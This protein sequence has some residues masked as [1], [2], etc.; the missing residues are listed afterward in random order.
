MARTARL[1]FPAL[2]WSER[3]GFDHEA[4]R[5]DEALRMGVGGFI[6]FGGDAGAVRE[7]TASLRQRS[8]EPLLI[9]ADLERGAGQQFRGATPLPPAAAL[10]EL[11]DLEVT[12]RAGELTAQEARALGVNWVYAPVADLD[13]EPRNPI[14]GTRSFGS[15]PARAAAHVTAWI[16]GCRAGGA[17]SCA[18]HFPG[19]GRTIAD[20]HAQLPVVMTSRQGLEK[21]LA[22]FRAAIRAGVDSVMTAHVAFPALDASGAPATLSEPIVQELLRGELGFDGAVVTDAL[23]MAGVLEG[24]GGAENAAVRAVAAGCDALLYPED[25]AA[26]ASALDA[27]LGERL[28]RARVEAAA[29]RIDRLAERAAQIGAGPAECGR[30]EDRAWA[31]GIAERALRMV[32]GTPPRLPASVD[33]VVVDDDIGGPY[34]P[35]SR[36]AFPAALRAAGIEAV[37]VAEPGPGRPALVAV[38]A[39]IRGW[40]GRAGLSDRAISSIATIL[41]AASDATVVLFGHPRLADELPDRA[42]R[43]LAAWGGEPLMQEAAAR[44][45]VA[46]RAGA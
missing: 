41:G 4:R 14:V 32:R 2:R 13:L 15:D 43:V 21:D 5:I 28:P 9:G 42:A 46:G 27:A 12:R 22:P 44:W 25:P 1:L 39:D 8:R 16:E 23:I 7:L 30:P 31:V 24:G 38:Y 37:E 35:P 40:K 3:T 36:D 11:D 20:S 26:V 10:A 6:V 29:A 34:P 33:L 45:L 17:L 19:H 18:K